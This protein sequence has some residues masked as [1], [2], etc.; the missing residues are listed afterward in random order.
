[1]KRNIVSILLGIAIF[2]TAF[3][4]NDWFSIFYH[5]NN[6]QKVNANNVT[7]IDSIYYTLSFEG[8]TEEGDSIMSPAINVAVADSIFKLSVDS[9]SNFKLRENI[10]RIYI[11]T[12][13]VV[14]EI[15][16]KE[17]YLSAKF[18]Y[19][20]PSGENGSFETIVD[21]KARGNNTWYFPKKPY[22]L[23]F[24]KKQTFPGLNKAKSFVLLAN[25][26]D[27]SLMKNAVAFRTAQL[28]GMPFANNAVPVEVYLNGTKRGSYM[29]TN[30]VG[31][32]S[33]S[34]DID[35]EEGVLWEW[36][37]Y[38]DEPY[39]FKSKRFSMPVMM[40]DPDVEELG[41]D[42]PVLTDSYWN[43]WRA[44][45]E[46]ALAKVYAGKWDEVLDP[47]QFVKFVLVN[48]IVHNNEITHPKST[49]VYKVRAGEKYC[50]GPVW[51]FD[52]ALGFTQTNP[53][54]RLATSGRDG[55]LFFKQ[56]FETDSFKEL[57]KKELD[58]FYNNKLDS[59]LSYIDDYSEEIRISALE[60]AELWPMDHQYDW[61]P[62]LRHAGH[63][64]DNV[65][66]IKDFILKR[67]EAIRADSRWLL[68]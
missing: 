12:D 24:D 54:L 19:E 4:V 59:L 9:I 50:F 3:G 2:S 55:Y 11:D 32:N 60:D 42:D 61:E 57:F 27:N 67:I 64:D 63:F 47:E 38:F 66:F 62:A 13:S 8:L 26:L 1:M 41:S 46:L 6:L 58:N 5:K 33:G 25:Y 37:T 16:D 17:N 52:W 65:A 31:I 39:K 21:I 14:D 36:D 35:E 28:V 40:K 43:F 56:I 48:N 53:G 34:V 7:D 44:D 20:A 51:D 18:S 45:M 30:K 15:T 49:F 22:R 29:L 10:A 68:Y 23:K